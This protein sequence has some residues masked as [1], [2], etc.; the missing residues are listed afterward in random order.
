MLVKQILPEARARLA[1]IAMDAPVTQ[2][3]RLMSQPHIDLVV[4]CDAAGTMVGILSKTDIVG[5]IGGCNGSSCMTRVDAIMTRAVVSCRP[6]AWLHD[7]WSE[8]KQQGLQ[9]IPIVDES[10]KP[11]GIIYARD[12]LQNLLRETENEESLLRDYVMT[13]GYR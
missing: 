8:M 11:I 3:A 12:A 10:H 9:R 13:V 7:I 2:A 5:Q 6:D 4:V 1:T